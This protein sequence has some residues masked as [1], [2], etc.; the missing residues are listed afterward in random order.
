MAGGAH[1]GPPALSR[2]RRAVRITQVLLVLVAAGLLV[3][4][5][6]SWGRASGYEAGR[7]ARTLDAPRPPSAAEVVVPALLGAGVLAAAFL[8]QGPT[9]VRVPTPARL[10][11]LSTRA[12]AA[13]LERAENP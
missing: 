13:A 3:F 10:E 4:S 7:R 9:G 8:L 1:R 6:Y 12:E 2:Q 11:E 5:G